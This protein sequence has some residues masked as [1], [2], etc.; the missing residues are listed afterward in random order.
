MKE[1]GMRKETG[2]QRVGLEGWERFDESRWTESKECCMI[3]KE[4]SRV[5][6]RNIAAGIAAGTVPDTE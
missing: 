3:K 4:L 1:S 2:K 5:T 6:G